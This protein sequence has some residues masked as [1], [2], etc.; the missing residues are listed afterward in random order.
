MG[1]KNAWLSFALNEFFKLEISSDMH[2]RTGIYLKSSSKNDMLSTNDGAG[3]R[4]H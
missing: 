1:H 4:H 3:I 2:D